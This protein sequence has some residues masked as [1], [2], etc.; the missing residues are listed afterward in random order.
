M[1]Y[2]W[3]SATLRPVWWGADPGFAAIDFIAS[4][5]AAHL[6]QDERYT[7]YLEKTGTDAASGYI[8]TATQAQRRRVI[9]ALTAALR[10]RHPRLVFALEVIDPGRS[11][12]APIVLRFTPQKEWHPDMYWGSGEVMRVR[13]DA[14]FRPTG[15]AAGL[16][17]STG[18]SFALDLRSLHLERSSE[19]EYLATC[20]AI[21]TGARDHCALRIESDSESTVKQ[22]Q[23]LYEGYLP[24]WLRHRERPDDLALKITFAAMASMRLRSV[25]VQ[26]VSRAVVADADLAA[27]STVRNPRALSPKEWAKR[28][29]FSLASN[30]PEGVS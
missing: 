27:R 30:F 8:A 4:T 17:L 3:A 23:L 5:V 2:L 1:A 12:T 28:Q 25:D 26:K 18:E 16:A 21:L 15:A 6:A 29:G 9:E 19:A 22:A 10:R 7:V 14:S 24:S 11:G 13:C 20:L